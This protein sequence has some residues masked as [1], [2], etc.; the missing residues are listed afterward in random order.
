MFLINLGVVFGTVYAVIWVE[1]Q[2]E[3]VK[4]FA[5]SNG[6]PGAVSNLVPTLFVSGHNAALPSVTKIIVK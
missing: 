6:L 5:E 3:E 1:E 4:E 2:K